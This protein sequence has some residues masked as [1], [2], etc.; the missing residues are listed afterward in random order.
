[1]YDIKNFM[2]LTLLLM[3]SMILLVSC[4]PPKK[5]AP[6]IDSQKP[7]SQTQSPTYQDSPVYQDKMVDTTTL[8]ERVLAQ[9]KPTDD[10]PYASLD[11][12]TL[13][14]KAE[15]L[16]GNNA[17][18]EALPFFKSAATREDGQLAKTYAG[19]YQTQMKLKHQSDA[20]QAFAQLLAI[21]LKESNQLNFRFLFEVGSTEFVND[22][23]LRT[24]Y[25][26][27]LREIAKYFQNRKSCFQ[28]VG[29]RGK[30]EKRND[31]Q[32]LS[33]LRAKAVQQIMIT[34]SPSITFQ[35]KVL[36]KGN[37]EN[38]SGIG[39]N[40]VMDTLDRRVEIVVVDCNE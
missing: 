9:T 29:H 27:W 13:L 36:G 37:S 38:L 21:S 20:E 34:H 17:Y 24:E 1:M 31:A 12:K 35:S 22:Q 25:S 18:E 30:N 32:K 6:K 10:E 40:D 39:S 19:L 33:L 3:V 28:I 15:T 7:P 8:D 26:F 23:A 5:P 16:Y 2:K 14:A 4:A 11:T